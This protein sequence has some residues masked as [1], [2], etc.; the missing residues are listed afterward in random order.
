MN[1]KVRN[2]EKMHN[3]YI[4]VIGEQEEN[5]KTVSVR[6]YKTKEQTVE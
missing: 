1:K 6:N 3:N 5:D 4:L 2:A